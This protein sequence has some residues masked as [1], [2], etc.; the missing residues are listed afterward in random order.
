MTVAYHKGERGVRPWGEWEVLEVGPTFAV[1][2]IRIL[3]GEKLSL[4][5]HRHRDEHWVIVAGS[6]TITLGEVTRP[7]GPNEPFHIPLGRVHSMENTGDVLLEFIEVQSGE[8]LDED[9][10]VRLSDPYNRD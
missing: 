7:V 5:V 6:G 2:R 3:P 9:D 10:I 1:K 4:Q 8:L